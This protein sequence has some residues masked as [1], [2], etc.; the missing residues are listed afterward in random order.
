MSKFDPSEQPH[1]RLNLLSGQWVLCSPHRA[2][3]PWQG[4]VPPP[5]HTHTAQ[6]TKVDACCQQVEKI[7]EAI[8][9]QYDPQCYLC[10][11]N[12][13]AAAQGVK[14][15]AYDHTFVFPNDFPTFLQ[16]PPGSITSFMSVIYLFIARCCG[17]FE[18]RGRPARVQGNDGRMPCHLLLA[19]SLGH[20]GRDGSAVDSTRRRH[21]AGGVCGAQ[22][23]VCLCAGL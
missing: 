16:V 11:G 2:K 5:P 19:R 1:R 6:K 20:G 21:V 8:R 23:A 13:R 14:N 7:E 22:P 10:P 12:A 18:Q 9:P 3:R 4:Q 17:Q 15:P